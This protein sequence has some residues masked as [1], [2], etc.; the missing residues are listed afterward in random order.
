MIKN[1]EKCSIEKIK[2]RVFIKIIDKGL[3]KLLNKVKADY[4][5]LNNIEV[6][7]VRNRYDDFDGSGDI[8]YLVS[9]KFPICKISENDIRLVD[10]STVIIEIDGFT[11]KNNILWDMDAEEMDFGWFSNWIVIKTKIK[12]NLSFIKDLEAE[13]IHCELDTEKIYEVGEYKDIS[14]WS[15]EEKVEGY[16]G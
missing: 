12:D 10:E 8:D 14:Y 3:V 13:L 11:Y 5:N 15:D 7:L 2:N 6:I 4:G 16:I 1:L 9:Y